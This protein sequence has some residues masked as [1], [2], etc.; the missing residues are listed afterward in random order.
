MDE[1]RIRE[2]TRKTVNA[3]KSKL[4][5]IMYEIF[6]EYL[7]DGRHYYENKD[8]DNYHVE[9][10]RARRVLC[11]L[12]G[13]LNPEIEMSGNLLSIYRFVERQ[14]IAADV[15][16][17]VEPLEDAL[18]LMDKLKKAFAVVAENDT[19]EPV[20][21]NTETVYAGLTYG[22]GNICENKVSQYSRG[23]LV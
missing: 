1:N 16:R 3:N 8:Y 13:A 19:S 17:K 20:M 12:I 4:I 9:V 23:I 15:G 11:N 6:E 7:I 14:L 10:S 18:R 5:V 21:K 22:P 2:Y